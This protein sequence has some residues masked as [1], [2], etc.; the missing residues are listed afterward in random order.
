MVF[1]SKTSRH[2][3]SAIANG[4][5]ECNVILDGKNGTGKTTTLNQIV[6][7]IGGNDIMV[8]TKDFY[9]V[10]DIPDIK[11]YLKRCAIMAKFINS[12]KYL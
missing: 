2:S 9:T 4:E 7:S 11:E 10:L 12:K 3:I 5:Y 1:G 8:E 6:H